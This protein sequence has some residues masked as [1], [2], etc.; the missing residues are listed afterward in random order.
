MWR[1]CLAWVATVTLAFAGPMMCGCSGR[2]APR[3]NA[4]DVIERLQR[5]VPGVAPLGASRQGASLSGRYTA[6]SER[7]RQRVGGF[8]DGGDLYL[9]RDRSFFYVEWADIL[10]RTICASGHWS[11]HDQ[12]VELSTERVLCKSFPTK[13]EPRYVAFSLTDAAGR[14]LRLLGTSRQ[15]RAFEDS[16]AHDELEL[17]MNSLEAVE[18]YAT[19]EESRRASEEVLRTAR[20]GDA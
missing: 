18:L 13:L 17:L 7:L 3:G 16:N 19:L 15:L 12:L 1:P 9:F 5:V 2:A 11:F 8:L 10:P 14:S 4:D 20:Q 6:E